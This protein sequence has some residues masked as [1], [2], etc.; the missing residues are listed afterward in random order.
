MKLIKRFLSLLAATGL[1]AGLLFTSAGPALAD[2]SLSWNGQ[3]GAT[4][5][6]PTTTGSVLWIFNPHS[7]AVPTELW[8]NGVQAAGSWEQSGGGQNWHFVATIPG[9][10]S[11]ITSA[12][13]VYTGDLGSNPVFTISGCNEGGGQPP[14]AD[15]TIVKDA[16]GTYDNEFTWDITKDVDRSSVEVTPGGTVTLNYTVTLSHDA[17]SIVNVVVTGNITVTN[18]NSADVTIDSLTDQLSDNT[19]CVVTPVGAQSATVMTPGNNDFTY[20]CDLPDGSVPS[21]LVNTATVSWSEQT[22][23]DGVSSLLAAGSTFFDANVAFTGTNIDDCATVTDTLDGAATSLGT[24]CVGEVDDVAGTFTITYTRNF[25]G[26]ALGTCVDHTNV[27]DF[28]DN[29]TPQ[30]TGDSGAV[31]VTV[32]AFNAPLTP[33]YWKTHLTFDSKHP[34]A[35]YTAKYLPIS[36]GNYVVNTTTKA[37]AVF[38]AMNCSKSGDQDAIGCLAGHLLAAKLNVANGANT[39]IN[40]TIAAADTFLISIN[41]TGPTGVYHLTPAQRATAITLKS[42]LDTYNNGGGC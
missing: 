40:T 4:A 2:G 29:S 31:T 1:L 15:L 10:F 20:E 13:V 30:Q 12:Y 32:C 25:T 38:N 33:G 22:L 34:T 35:P 41:Y 21:G 27:A 7:D 24:H 17:G 11:D 23:N 26:P 14:A 42:A 9:Q 16:A 39:C 36:L 8:I 18:P 6:S 19:V 28:A 5:C 37:T 3:N